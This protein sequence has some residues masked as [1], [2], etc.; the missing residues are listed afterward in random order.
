MADGDLVEPLLETPCQA[1]QRIHTAD[2]CVDTAGESLLLDWW[3][4]QPKLQACCS[5]ISQNFT[6]STR[7]RREIKVGLFPQ[8]FDFKLNSPK[9]HLKPYLKATP[10]D[11]Y[12]IYPT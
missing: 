5:A 2:V 3:N 12:T 10:D 9:N 7:T 4:S 8:A 1:V 11:S 6:A